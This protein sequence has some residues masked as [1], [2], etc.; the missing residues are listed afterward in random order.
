LDLKNKKDVSVNIDENLKLEYLQKLSGFLK[1]IETT[2]Y[3]F[4]K[5][6]KDCHCEYSILCF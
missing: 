4:I 3:S 5:R 1:K 6:K 2:D